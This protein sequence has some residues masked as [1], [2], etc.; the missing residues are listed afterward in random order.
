MLREKNKQK[1]HTN[2]LFS[3]TTLEKKQKNKND[4]KKSS[5]SMYQSIVTST[6]PYLLI[7]YYMTLFLHK[8][9]Y[10]ERRVDH[11]IMYEVK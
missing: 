6:A 10:D 4:E 9:M 2:T 7:L 11:K 3:L 5:S 8:M 1:I